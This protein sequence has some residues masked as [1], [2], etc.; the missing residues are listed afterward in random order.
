MLMIITN[1]ISFCYIQ[2]INIFYQEFYI[3]VLVFT[4]FCIVYNGF[5]CLNCI[6]YCL[7]K[8]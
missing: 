6:L 8:V 4:V 1:N 7:Y 5:Y 2:L 3:S